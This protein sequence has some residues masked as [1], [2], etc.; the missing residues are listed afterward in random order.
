MNALNGQLAVV[1]VGRDH[2]QHVLQIRAGKT[3]CGIGHSGRNPVRDFPMT[4]DKA[5]AACLAELINVAIG[6]QTLPPPEDVHAA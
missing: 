3:L 6:N 5:C 4:Q 2:G 1:V